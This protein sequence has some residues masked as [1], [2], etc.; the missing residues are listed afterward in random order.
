MLQ[1]IVPELEKYDEIKNEFIKSKEQVLQLEHS[2]VSLSKWESKWCKAFLTK[3]EKTIE[4]T[5]DYIRCM[6]ITQNVDP[7]AYVNITNDNIRTVSRYIEMP[8]TATW[9]Y[10]EQTKVNRDIITSE[11]IYYWMISL[12]I[13]F[14]CQ[15]W[16]LNRLLTL[17]K[18]CKEKN[19]K[20]KKMSNNEVMSRNKTL[21][22]SRR[23]KLNSKG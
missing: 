16:H 6:T 3:E 4:E 7:Q 23:K 15:K 20:P 17:I 1:I 11:I 10:N 12:T 18:V 22:D 13:P 9:F 21:N 8:M 5:I 14:D 19:D 2:L